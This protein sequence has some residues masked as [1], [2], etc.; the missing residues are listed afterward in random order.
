MVPPAEG[1]ALLLE[2]PLLHCVYGLYEVEPFGYVYPFAEPQEPFVGAAA[3]YT[4]A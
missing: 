3:T 2:E 4:V 1:N